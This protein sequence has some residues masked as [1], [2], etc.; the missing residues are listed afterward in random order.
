MSEL[1]EK[2]LALKKSEQ[3]LILYGFIIIILVM[4]YFYVWQPYKQSLNNLNENIINTQKD[5]IWLKQISGQVKEL[6]SAKLLDLGSF[7]GSL[8]N[9][10]DKSI[11][12]HRM[13]NQVSLLENSGSNRVVVQI[14]KISFNTLIK[15]LGYIK[16]RYGI[17]VKSIELNKEEQSQLINAHL[18]L[19]KH[20]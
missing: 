3:Q 18:I 16:K 11:K 17:L 10:I 2:W 4:A 7:E 14:N 15:W 20:N 6:K 1:K 13:M 12:Q 5:I 8:I 19:K 9:T